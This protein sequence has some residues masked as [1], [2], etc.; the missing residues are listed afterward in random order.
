MDFPAIVFNFPLYS[1][2][3]NHSY[4]TSKYPYHRFT[5]GR[6][7][8]GEV[9]LVVGYAVRCVIIYA[10]DKVV[11]FNRKIMR[12]TAEVTIVRLGRKTFG[13]NTVEVL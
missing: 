5:Y 2:L 9:L 7:C 3:A 11:E 4:H 10:Y 1:Y 13:L 12:L 8:C 6:D